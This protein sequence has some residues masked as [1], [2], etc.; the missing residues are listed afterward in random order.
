MLGEIY[1]PAG[2]ALEHAQAVLETENAYAVNVALGCKMGCSYCYGPGATYQNRES[3][4]NVR[5]PTKSPLELVRRQLDKGLCPNGVFI[6]FLTEPLHPK[7]RDSTEELASFLLSQDIRVAISSKL[8]IASDP[9]VRH[10]MTVVSVDPKF[11][12]NFEG[13]NPPPKSRINTLRTAHNLGEYTWAS[14]EPLPCP[15]IWKQDILEVLQRLDFVD[16]L[17]L[18]KWNYDKRSSTDEARSYYR[19]AVHTFRD[20]CAEHGI[21]HHVK[22][23]TVK[24]VTA[25]HQHE[26]SSAGGN[27]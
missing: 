25:R 27:T 11:S 9:G 13:V 3:W 1:H 14:L 5:Y 16:F 18:G 7:V 8:G 23:G 19:D 26:N 17:I 10:G 21:R 20:F 15:A 12:H 2:K 22:A 24:F 4:R 6:S